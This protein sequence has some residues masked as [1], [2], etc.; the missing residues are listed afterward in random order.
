MGPVHPGP[1]TGTRPSASESAPPVSR[2]RWRPACN[3]PG[4][5]YLSPASN[6]Q[7]LSTPN[8]REPRKQSWTV[9]GDV[10]TAAGRVSGSGRRLLQGRR[11]CAAAVSSS[12]L[13]RPAHRSAHRSA[14]PLSTAQCAVQLRALACPRVQRRTLF[15]QYLSQCTRPDL[16]AIPVTR[17]SIA[18]RWI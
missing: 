9:S 1:G 14:P 5:C 4:P 10:K 7:D 15:T 3:P 12:R 11:W 18:V 16:R 6:H 13:Q 17:V 2:Q 8:R